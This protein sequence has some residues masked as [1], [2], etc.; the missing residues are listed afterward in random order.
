MA[1][2]GINRGLEWHLHSASRTIALLRQRV[3]KASRLSGASID[4]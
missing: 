4:A 1:L 2:G 3:F